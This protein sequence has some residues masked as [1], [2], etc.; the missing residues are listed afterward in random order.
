MSTKNKSGFW[1]LVC[2]LGLIFGIA[3]WIG[4]VVM[5]FGTL[6]WKNTR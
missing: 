4:A 6:I 3:L 5:L 2:D 1:G